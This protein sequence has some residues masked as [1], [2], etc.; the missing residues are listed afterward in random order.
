MDPRVRQL[1]KQ[2]VYMAKEYPAES[3]GYSRLVGQAK[4]AF[5]GTEIGHADDMHRALS[6]GE[7]IV[8]GTYEEPTPGGAD[9]NP[10]P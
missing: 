7:Y 3:G 6:K 2:L 4:R 5:R 10:G 8:K 9:R 1:F